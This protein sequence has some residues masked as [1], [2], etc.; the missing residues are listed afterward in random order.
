MATDPPPPAGA[1]PSWDAAWAEALDRLE[2]DL[3]RMDRLL[4][5]A[6][7]PDEPAWT[8]PTGLGPL[9]AHLLPR[10]L[11]LQERQGAMM[12]R[13][14][15]GLRETQHTRAYAEGQ[16]RAEREVPRYLDVVG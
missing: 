13:L 7:V 14:A 9:P 1:P 6:D 10:A 2:R 5:A 8:P 15:G 12:T 4:G 16:D 11:E 3:H